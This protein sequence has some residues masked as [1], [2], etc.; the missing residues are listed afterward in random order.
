[1]RESWIEKGAKE[2]QELK[3]R[4][5]SGKLKDEKKIAYYLGNK[6]R[7]YH[8]KRYFSFEIGKGK[9]RFFLDAEKLRFEEEC[10]GKYLIRTTDSNLSVKEVIREYKNLWEIESC[11]REIKDVIKIR[12]IYHQ[13]EERTKAHIFIAVIAYLI[14][15]VLQRRLR[16]AKIRIT[17]QDA[18]EFAKEVKVVEL[19]VGKGS[20]KL[21]T[22]KITDLTKQIFDLMRINLP[23]SFK[24]CK[25][26]KFIYKNGIQRELF[27]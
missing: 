13:T 12:P 18:L 15:K 4:I 23:K 26:E 25:I 17:A 24:E 8:I 1:M 3:E 2:L 22:Q 14:E 19:E 9:F 7:K 5:N 6:A 21:I 10:E 11:F 27:Y 16:E 20:I